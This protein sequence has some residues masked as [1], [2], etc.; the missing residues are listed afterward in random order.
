MKLKT[1]Q[2]KKPVQQAKI[3]ITLEISVPV[4]KLDYCIFDDQT[5]DEELVNFKGTTTQDLVEHVQWL[6][7]AV[8]EDYSSFYTYLLDNCLN[9]REFDVVG[10]DLELEGA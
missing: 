6:M 4:T 7:K 1:A 8:E 2:I 9:T 5:D 10:I 3:Q